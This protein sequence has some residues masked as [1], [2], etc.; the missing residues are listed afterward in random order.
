MPNDFYDL[1]IHDSA[2]CAVTLNF[3]DETSNHD[4]NGETGNCDAC[5]E[6]HAIDDLHVIVNSRRGRAYNLCDE[7]YEHSVVTCD[8][9]GEK[10]L[11]WYFYEATINGER[12]RFCTRKCMEIECEKAN[13]KKCDYCGSYGNELIP[14]DL[15]LNGDEKMVC[16]SCF[17]AG[18]NEYYVMPYDYIPEYHTYLEHGDLLRGGT[19]MNRAKEANGVVYVGI[20][21]EFEGGET[22]DFIYN[23]NKELR[24]RGKGNV[25]YFMHDGSLR[26]GVEVTSCIVDYEAMMNGDYPLEEIEKFANEYGMKIKDTCGFHVHVNRKSLGNE[27]DERELT[28]AKVV[29]LFDKF[30]DELLKVSKRNRGQAERYAQKPNAYIESDDPPYMACEKARDKCTD[31]YACVNLRPRNTIEFRLWGGAKNAKTVK[32]LVDLTVTM[33]KIAKDMALADIAGLSWDKFVEILKNRVSYEH[34]MEM[35]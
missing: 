8:H 20:E 14:C 19:W 33:T 17:E 21:Q 22:E 1:F 9:C 11:S 4:S 10:G 32:S 26:N 31:H 7:C 29:L 35:F 12:K 16:R 3:S 18:V 24:E 25:L 23:L 30:Y 6:P 5:G 34:T 2:H 27:H 13:M 15:F 28:A